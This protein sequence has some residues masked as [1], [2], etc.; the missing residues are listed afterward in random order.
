MNRLERGEP[1]HLILIKGDWLGS[2]K[3]AS[4]PSVNLNQSKKSNWW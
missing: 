1:I 3:L 2:W 4:H